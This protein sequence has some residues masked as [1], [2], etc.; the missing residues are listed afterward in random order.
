M[1][2][3]D[4]GHP[5]VTWIRQL[6]EG[7]AARLRAEQ[8][9][10][11]HHDATCSRLSEQLQQQ[12]AA[13]PQVLGTT[14]QAIEGEF[15]TKRT[16]VESSFDSEFQE[17]K[18]QYDQAIQEIQ[19]EY[20]RDA[21]EAKRQHR[22]LE[23]M[24]ESVFDESSG[25]NPP[26]KYATYRRQATKTREFLETEW[27]HLENL[28]DDSLAL[29]QSRHM[30][31][32]LAPVAAR[33]TAG[34]VDQLLASFEQ[35]AAA[36]DRCS[37]QVKQQWVARLFSGVF[38]LYWALAIWL[39]ATPAIIGMRT[40]LIDAIQQPSPEQWQWLKLASGL[41]A[42]ATLVLLGTTYTVARL[43]TRRLLNSLFQQLTD[44]RAALTQWLKLSKT[45]L[46]NLQRSSDEWQQQ[47]GQHRG[48]S[49]DN[50]ARAQLRRD[51]QRTTQR[52]DDL[53][54]VQEQFVPRLQQI[55]D[56]RDRQIQDLEAQRKKQIQDQTES[57]QRDL[58][59]QEQALQHS[60]QQAIHDRKQHWTR[61]S[62]DW[63]QLINDIRA[64]IQQLDARV[65][66]DYPDWDQLANAPWQ[67]PDQIPTAVPIGHFNVD[68]ANFDHG[69]PSDPE[70][71][72]IT[73][74]L[75]VPAMLP[76]PI[77]SPLLMKSQGRGRQQAVHL[78]KSLMLRL[79][80]SLPAGTAR[81]TII[82]PVGLGEEF[83][84]FMHLADYDELLVTN[85]I[86]T[87]SSHIE[88][89]LTDLTLHMENVFQT[90]LRNEFQNIQD[91]NAHAGE[92]AEPYHILVIANFPANFS[93]NAIRR[94]TSIVSSG[95]R[96]GIY[97]LISLDTQQQLPH[98]FDL[99]D[100]ESSSNTLR[101]EDSGCSWVD[102]QLARLPF[103]PQ[104]PPAGD[105]IG[106]IVRA[107]GEQSSHARRV[108][109][110][111]SRIAPAPNDA[112]TNDSRQG[113]NVPLG[114][115]GATKLQRLQ[116]GRGTS[117]HVLIAGKT[118]S[119][120]STLLHAIIVNAALRYSPDELEF[121]LIDFKKGVEFKAYATNTLPHARV[122]AIES[123]REFGL[124]VL[125]RL[126]EILKERGD[127]FR[128]AAVQD[129]TAYREQC[130]QVRLPRIMLI[131]DEFQEFFVEDDRLAQNAALLLDRLVRQ[132]RAFGIH[133]LLGSQTLA[134]SYSLPRS[135]LG[136]VAIR[137]ALQCS[138][139]DAHLI[140]SEENTAARLLTRPGEAIYNDANGL[141]EGNHPFQVA[142]LPEQERDS[143]LQR[144]A[145]LTKD[146][147]H[148]VLPPTVFEG[149]IPANPE[150]NLELLTVLEAENPT[151]DTTQ[152]IGWLGEAIAIKAP[153]QIRFQRRNGF[154]L[155]LCGPDQD[156]AQGICAHCL[157]SVAAQLP[158]H[159]HGQTPLF[160]ILAADAVVNDPLSV[161][162][163]LT[164]VLP[165]SLNLAGTPQTAE[166]MQQIT[167]EL[168]QRQAATT[169]DDPP[170]ILVLADLAQLPDL[171]KDE[172]DFGFGSSNA[173]TPANP[174]QQLEEILK[175]GPAVGIHT[176][177][178]CDTLNNF[179]RTFTTQLQREFELRVGFQMSANDSSQF[180]DSP[181]AGK[182]GRNRAVLYQT[183]DGSHERFRPYSLPSDAWLTRLSQH[184]RAPSAP[185]PA[186]NL[187]RWDVI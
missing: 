19:Q 104:H 65:Q 51:Q 34:N 92:V 46:T 82:D 26:Q 12:R 159:R 141:L 18:A 27:G 21:A 154:N 90:Y 165:Q 72:N 149:Q 37:G 67:S 59:H 132:G 68:L 176:L 14:L 155:M 117:Q 49:L 10:T 166:V 96:C 120:K 135:T 52:D 41:S 150:R 86:W 24:V 172:E 91:Y 31:M 111:F 107:V 39:L 60:Q 6:D 140:L 131:I 11:D 147:D 138:E 177:S 158:A 121:Y 32:Q 35:S 109:V 101:C 119:G 8:E 5:V 157:I 74:S 77:D 130:P 114:R 38:P 102:P 110:S 79:L 134:G 40:N 70:L 50:A 175:H 163:R 143:V 133:I 180:L 103:Q 15:T 160:Q 25:E 53:E 42:F 22:D 97:T 47:F 183:S 118:G 83:S 57:Q 20:D 145:Q 66:Q 13:Q 187:D 2:T 84:A 167:S 112:W 173:D 142:W 45:T 128:Q 28:Y 186:V 73:G 115:A 16:A 94:L 76:F 164:R 87:E 69:V 127:A 184:L 170:L 54:A 136:Q 153:T 185:D 81:F 116:L 89:R 23:W 124:S 88:K 105:T 85:R 62:N 139:T 4:S 98:N 80:T 99:Q 129:V 113:I 162:N 156:A 58:Q 61:M 126:D 7:I 122:V 108:E 43:R 64:Q 75:P 171:R 181:Q 106:K 71:M 168:Q 33:P 1:S 146:H 137:I 100:L 95:P 174:A 182:L 78:L 63:N 148:Q 152:P 178:W 169:H 144:I 9:L 36:A 17:T 151:Q 30:G 125:E 29:A 44:A 3:P 48:R 161:W 123:D 93:D 55:V 56:E 179:N